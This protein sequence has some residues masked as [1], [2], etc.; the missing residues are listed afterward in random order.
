MS[1]EN[2]EVMKA[3][4]QAWNGDM[5]AFRE[6]HDRDVIARSPEGWPEPG[7]F[8]GREAVMRQWEQMRETWD[9]DAL[10]PIDFIDAGD[11][12]VVRFIWR[13]VGRGPELNMEMTGVYSVREGKIT[14]FE[15]FWDHSKALQAVG[16]A[17]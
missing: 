9:A 13:G 14:V 2:V 1:E 3:A 10:K 12:V 4:F 11:R 16:L 8:I 5:D 15:F 7:P 17:G 6:M